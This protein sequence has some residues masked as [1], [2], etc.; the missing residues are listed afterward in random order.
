MSHPMS[1]QPFEFRLQLFVE[2]SLPCSLIFR[3]IGILS[4]LFLSKTDESTRS[5]FVITSF[6]HG[7]AL[8][9]F[10][11]HGLCNCTF[12]SV[13]LSPRGRV[14]NIHRPEVIQI[15]AV[16]ISPSVGHLRFSVLLGSI[17]AMFD[18]CSCGV[19]RWNG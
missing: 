10:C 11:S 5:G 18:R 4:S 8:A 19:L 15:F 7:S 13:S 16:L 14:V 3:N 1:T 9:I 17:L 2:W 12:V 6:I